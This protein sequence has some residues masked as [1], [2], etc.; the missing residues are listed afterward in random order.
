[1]MTPEEALAHYQ[2][3]AETVVR[4]LLDMDARIQ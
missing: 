4:V 2:A 3:G 1:M